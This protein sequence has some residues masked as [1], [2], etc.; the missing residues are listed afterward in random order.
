MATNFRN[1][2]IFNLDAL[3]S[4]VIESDDFSNAIGESMKAEVES[5]IETAI[6]EY[7][8]NQMVRD[9]MPDYGDDITGIEED[10]TR[11]RNEVEDWMNAD[12][13]AEHTGLIQ[14]L[15]EQNKNFFFA[16]AAAEE[17]IKSLEEKNESITDFIRDFYRIVK[18]SWFSK[19]KRLFP[20]G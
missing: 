20:W 18:Q 5:L 3:V 19:F 4:Y 9:E 17:R 8:F 1:V 16:L 13:M 14:A 10:M 11:L 7:D 15:Q 12:L 6:G 2:D